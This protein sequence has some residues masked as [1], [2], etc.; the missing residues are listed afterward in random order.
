MLLKH[1]SLFEVIPFTYRSHEGI[2]PSWDRLFDNLLVSLLLARSL[3]R[4]LG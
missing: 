2:I 1:L 3:G 4:R